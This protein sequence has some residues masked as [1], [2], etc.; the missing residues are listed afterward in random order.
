MYKR[1]QCYLIRNGWMF[2]SRCA[3]KYDKKKR[4]KMNRSPVTA[5]KSNFRLQ[6]RIPIMACSVCG[7]FVEVAW[8]SSEMLLGHNHWAYIEVTHSIRDRERKMIKWFHIFTCSVV[9]WFCVCCSLLFIYLFIFLLFTSN[10]M[11]FCSNTT[12]KSQKTALTTRYISNKQKM[13][14]SLV[15]NHIKMHLIIINCEG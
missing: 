10:S 3:V 4:V 2:N 14:D 1:C 6:K 5:T 15:R 11:P 13:T 8:I 12:S 7:T 9:C